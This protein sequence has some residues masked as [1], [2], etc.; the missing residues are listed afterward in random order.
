[1]MEAASISE[2]SVNYQTAW[3]YKQEDSHRH[4]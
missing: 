1:M 4:T 2:T 3:R